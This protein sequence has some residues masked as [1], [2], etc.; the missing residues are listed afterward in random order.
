M[1]NGLSIVINW[2]TGQGLS[3]DF[4]GRNL[5][6]TYKFCPNETYSA[7]LLDI[8]LQ[9]KSYSRKPGGVTIIITLAT[10]HTSADVHQSLRTVFHAINQHLYNRLN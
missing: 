7:N 5:I 6:M 4:N 1:F 9:P 2:M 8:S 10:P 3:F